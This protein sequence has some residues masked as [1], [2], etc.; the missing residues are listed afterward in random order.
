MYVYIYIHAYT[1]V[2]VV[3]NICPVRLHPFDET[4]QNLGNISLDFEPSVP[5]FS[6]CHSR[7]HE[8]T[9]NQAAMHTGFA[10]ANLQR[11][12]A[13]PLEACLIFFLATRTPQEKKTVSQGWTGFPPSAG[14]SFSQVSGSHRSADSCC[15]GH[16][17]SFIFL[18]S[19]H[20]KLSKLLSSCFK[21]TSSILQT[22]TNSKSNNVEFVIGARSVFMPLKHI[23]AWNEHLPYSTVASIF[24]LL[25]FMRGQRWPSQ[26]SGG[27]VETSGLEL[28]VL[29]GRK[30][31]RKHQPEHQHCATASCEFWPLQPRDSGF[32]WRS[33]S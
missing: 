16:L 5:H 25:S 3:V 20:L 30:T 32:I 29:Y 31:Y 12:D 9:C 22:S 10:W 21:H 33:G 11:L 18:P 17:T 15:A 8:L 13:T 24:I 14:W 4:N 26:N 1:H 7:T 6:R 19:K 27:E 23:P 2:P 28:R